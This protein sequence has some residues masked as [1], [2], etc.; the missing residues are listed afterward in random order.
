MHVAR[1]IASH[2]CLLFRATFAFFLKSMDRDG[3]SCD[4]WEGSKREYGE[5]RDSECSEGR[6]S[7]PQ[8]TG[9]SLYIPTP[10]RPR[11]VV[12][13][14]LLLNRLCLIEL[15]QL[16]NFIN[17]VNEIRSCTTSGCKGMLAPVAV[18]CRGLGG[19]ITV[20]YSCDGCNLKGATFEAN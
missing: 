14:I 18:K 16:G 12:R 4:I 8:A 2:W 15:S 20:R 10:E 3:E 11:T 5:V 1:S 9:G 19:A 13:P 17:T 6:E 7:E